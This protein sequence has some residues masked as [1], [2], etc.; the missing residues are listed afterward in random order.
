MAIT[1]RFLRYIKFE[2]TSDEHTDQCPSTNGQNILAEA[3][4]TELI[5]IGVTD[6]E[7]SKDGYVYATMKA[8]PTRISRP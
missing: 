3:L 1:D 4:K 7:V 5:E 2:T 6:A 8:T